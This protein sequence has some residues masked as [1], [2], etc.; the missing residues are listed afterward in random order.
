MKII[1]KEFEQAYKKKV[2]V[3]QLFNGLIVRVH[4]ARS[5]IFRWRPDIGDK[6]ISKLPVGVEHFR[7]WIAAI[8]ARDYEHTIWNMCEKNKTVQ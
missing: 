5:I 7:N 4:M 3:E 6:S 8:K 1:P 2:L